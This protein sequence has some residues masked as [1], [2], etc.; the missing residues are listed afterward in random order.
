MR[1]LSDCKLGGKY[2]FD[3]T[4]CNYSFLLFSSSVFCNSRFVLLWENEL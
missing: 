4:N 3:F 1:L 2:E